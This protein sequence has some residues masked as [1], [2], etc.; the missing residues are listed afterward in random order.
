MKKIFF[1]IEGIAGC[2]SFKD[3]NESITV[4]CQ[5]LPG[6]RVEGR[7]FLKKIEKTIENKSDVIRFEARGVGYS[8]GDFVHLTYDSW[9]DDILKIVL[10]F[11]D[12]NKHRKLYLIFMSEAA[13]LIDRVIL[14]LQEKIN[15]GKIVILLMNGIITKEE[16]VSPYKIKYMR[17]KSGELG[18]YTGF[19][20]LFSSTFIDYYPDKKRLQNILNDT[21]IEILGIYGEED[22]LTV[23]SRSLLK[24]KLNKYFSILNGDHLFTSINAYKQVISYIEEIYY[25]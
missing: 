9:N 3:K 17:G 22:S 21:T 11:F 20:V 6:N 4:I 16:I 24:F 12:K 8:E 19:G 23:N 7:N 18:I 14:G 5:G 13:K 2:H 25:A 1:N 10:N 15:S